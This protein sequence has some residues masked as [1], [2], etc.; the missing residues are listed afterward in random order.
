MQL[1]RHHVWHGIQAPLV[2]S[3]R[4]DFSVERMA[5]GGTCLQVQTL[6]IRRH[7]SPP[8]WPMKSMIITA[9]LGLCVLGSQEA[10]AQS[11]I[12]LSLANSEG[13]YAVGS[14][15]DSRDV[16]KE[17]VRFLVLLENTSNHDIGIYR[18]WNSWGYYAIHFVVEGADG[19]QAV[20]KKGL[21]A[22]SR[23]YPDCFWLAPGITH[24]FP[25]CFTSDEWNGLEALSAK[26]ARL[27][28]V[29]QQKPVEE[30]LLV[31]TRWS[32]VQMFTNKV[33]STF[34]VWQAFAKPRAN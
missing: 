16:A 21:R 32:A 4:P 2:M 8:R 12:R 9:L 3:A 31:A 5:A 27:K 15:L 30:R 28:A 23:N 19:T 14:S 10:Q 33:E 17:P 11:A 25:I 26:G 24:A 29:F 1:Y 13:Y 34:V 20:I 18:Q 22:W 6:G 7:R